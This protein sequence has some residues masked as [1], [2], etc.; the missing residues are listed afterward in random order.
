MRKKHSQ[1]LRLKIGAIYFKIRNTVAISVMLIET[2]GRVFLKIINYYHWHKLGTEWH[3]RPMLMFQHNNF[4][5][6]LWPTSTLIASQLKSWVQT[7]SLALGPLGIQFRPCT[8]KSLTQL[9]A[10]CWWSYIAIRTC[11]NWVVPDNSAVCCWSTRIFVSTGIYTLSVFTCSIVR[12]FVIGRATHIQARLSRWGHWK[13][14]HAVMHLRRI[15][16]TVTPESF[17]LLFLRGRHAVKGSPWNP[18]TQEHSAL[19]LELVQIAFVPH[20]V[21]LHASIQFPSW[22]MSE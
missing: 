18:C 13:K 16:P 4:I 12:A 9:T 7:P 19:W 10:C 1:V 3:L 21:A 11:T 15:T 6:D 20:F 5:P 17:T 8:S 2:N 14:Q 22:Q